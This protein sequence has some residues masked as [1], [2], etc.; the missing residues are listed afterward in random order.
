MDLQERVADYNG[1]LKDEAAGVTAKAR[2]VS[3]DTQRLA[4]HLTLEKPARQ[5]NPVYLD[6]I[7]SKDCLACRAPAPCQ[8]HHLDRGGMGTKGPDAFTVPLCASCHGQLHNKPE[9][10]FWDKV[11]GTNPWKAACELLRAF[12]EGGALP[13]TD[14]VAIDFEYDD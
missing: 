14:E 12:Y 5:E 11:V 2:E 6:Y 10:E 7:R 9:W 3:S 8:P 13:A 4:E 1:D